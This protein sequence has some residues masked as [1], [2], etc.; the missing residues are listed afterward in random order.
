MTIEERIADLERQ[1]VEARKAAEWVPI[2]AEHLP[3]VGD[4]VL[5]ATSGYVDSVDTD[6]V[7]YGFDSWEHYGY[8]HYRPIN[9]P[10]GKEHHD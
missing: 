7:D 6:N 8:T 9:A 10:Q 3:E 1:L 5:K 4:E 2:D